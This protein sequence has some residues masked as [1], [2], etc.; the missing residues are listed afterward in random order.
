MKH[1]SALRPRDFVGSETWAYLGNS[2]YWVVRHDCVGCRCAKYAEVFWS[3]GDGSLGWM[4][5]VLFSLMLGSQA[6]EIGFKCCD[7]EAQGRT[8]TPKPDSLGQSLE[9]KSGSWMRLRCAGPLTALIYLQVKVTFFSI[10]N[11]LEKLCSFSLKQ[12]FRVSWN[13]SPMY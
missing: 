10:L 1:P 7:L 6:S 12:Y 5:E 3:K 8:T 4:V 9:G 13:S 11:T 2:D